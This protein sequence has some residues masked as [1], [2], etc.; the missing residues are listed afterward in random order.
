MN[1]IPDIESNTPWLPLSKEGMPEVM[2]NKI[3]LNVSKVMKKQLNRPEPLRLLIRLAGAAC[4]VLF[5]V[6]SFEQFNT[7]HK[8]SL[9][10]NRIAEIK[11]NTQMDFKA[12]NEL[13]IINSFI[14]WSD[15]KAMKL[16]PS[17][18]SIENQIIPSYL[19]SNLFG[20]KELKEKFSKYLRDLQLATK[21]YIP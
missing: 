19:K 5:L 17:D 6:Y 4:F 16:S 13:L 10:E 20:D 14:S 12:H 2:K 18:Q 15:I 21:I 11:G 8:I 7:I 3:S 1:N 9:L